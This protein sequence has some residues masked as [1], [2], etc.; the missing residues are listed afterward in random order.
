ML[1]Y[2]RAVDTMH[3]EP[4]PPVSA[5]LSPMAEFCFNGGD[6]FSGEKVVGMLAG[7]GTMLESFSHEG[8]DVRVWDLEGQDGKRTVFLETTS[9]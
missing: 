8:F 7:R 1:K 9:V 5:F 6:S 3:K 4:D 2:I